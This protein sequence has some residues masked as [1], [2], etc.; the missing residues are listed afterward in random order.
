MTKFNSKSIF[1]SPINYLSIVGKKINIFKKLGFNSF[2]GGL[3]FGAVFSLIVNMVTVKVQ[4]IIQKQRILESVEFEILNNYLQANN[5]AAENTK[6]IVEKSNPNIFHTISPYFNDLLTQSTEP[7][8]YIA[9]L[10]PSIQSQL[11]TYYS[12]IVKGQN[13]MMFKLND[14]AEKKLIDCYDFSVLEEKEQKKC[15]NDYYSILDI[16]ADSADY[17]SKNSFELLDTFHPTKDRLNN[18]I[19]RLFMGNKSVR[20]LSHK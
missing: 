3:V 9:Q 10:D 5:I 12:I 15:L 18:P 1:S 16:E 11:T 19:L 2:V 6:Q 14:Y 4:E 13:E 17:M 7:L 20:I 8:Q